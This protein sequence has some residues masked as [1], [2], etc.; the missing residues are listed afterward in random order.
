LA[1]TLIAE[2][3]FEMMNTMNFNKSELLKANTDDFISCKENNHPFFMKSG[4]FGLRTKPS[5][6]LSLACYASVGLF[7]FS[8]FCSACFYFW[9]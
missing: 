1:E 3:K 2:S 5:G 4:Y 7:G 8:P 6:D 9:T